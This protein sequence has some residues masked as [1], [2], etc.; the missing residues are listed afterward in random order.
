MAKTRATVPVGQA[1]RVARAAKRAPA[2]PQP[3]EPVSS[4]AVDAFLARIGTEF[5]GLSRQLK[6]IARYVEQHRDHIALER[7][8]DVAARCDVQPSAV[9]RFAKH[10]GY[11]GWSEMQ[12][13][14]RDGVAQRIAPSRNYQERIREAID[15][16]TGRLSAADIAHEFISGSIA[17]LQELQRDLHPTT[18]DEAV[19]L[20]AR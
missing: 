11:S 16:A 20:L 4:S 7:I 8:Q 1:V 3:A 13:I 15:S 17:G 19:E 12:K 10:F 9:I 18:F 6:Q 2:T 14:F 5:E